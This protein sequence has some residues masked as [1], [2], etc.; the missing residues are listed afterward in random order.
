MKID[1]TQRIA[2]IDEEPAH[3][4]ERGRDPL[5]GEHPGFGMSA[6]ESANPD[7]ERQVERRL[8]GE[9]VEVFRGDVTHAQQAGCY[10]CSGRAAT[11]SARRSDGR[12]PVVMSRHR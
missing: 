1:Q 4:G 12:A 3:R 9:E 2:A 10:L 6:V 11:T 8:A 5:S 7:R